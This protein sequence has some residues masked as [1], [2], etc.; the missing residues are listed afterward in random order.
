[1]IDTE[2]HIILISCKIA[3]KIE[4]LYYHSCVKPC[5]RRH[6]DAY[7]IFAA[8]LL[9]HNLICRIILIFRFSQT[10]RHRPHSCSYRQQ[11]TCLTAH[12]AKTNYMWGNLFS[13]VFSRRLWIT[14]LWCC[15]FKKSCSCF[16]Q[17][18]SHVNKSIKYIDY[19]NI[20]ANL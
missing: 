2:V 6:G 17:K 13:G 16:I 11:L 5:L 10:H 8:S 9:Q 7:V 4:G 19:Y 20:N 15:V 14:F 18:L 12:Q 3:S 1:M